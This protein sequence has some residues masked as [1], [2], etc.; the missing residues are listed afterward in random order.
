MKLS[1]ALRIRSVA[2]VI[3]ATLLS[4]N[5]LFGGIVLSYAFDGSDTDVPRIEQMSL[6]NTSVLK[7]N[8]PIAIVL[9]TSDDKNWVK[10]EGTLNIGYSYKL[11][12]G[13]NPPP[14]CSTVT[15][16]F[17]KLEAIEIL[18]LRT[19]AA[20]GQRNQTFWLMGYLPA[21][22]ALVSNCAEYRDL[23]QA[24]VV[25]VNSTSFKSVKPKGSSV[26]IITGG[27]Y[28][29]KLVDEAGRSEPSAV[30]QRL[31]EWQFLPGNYDYEAT[32]P[33]QKYADSLSFRVKNQSALDQ[34]ELEAK[35]ARDL[36]NVEGIELATQVES[37]LWQVDSWI[38]FAKSPSFDSLKVVPACAIPSSTNTLIKAV[39]EAKLKLKLSNST[40]F[41]ANLLSRCE[42]FQGK[43]LDLE[44]RVLAARDMFKKTKM[45]DAFLRIS[46][47]NLRIDCASSSITDLGLSTRDS[48]FQ[49][50]EKDF[51]K[52]EQ[53]ALSQF[54]CKPFNLRLNLLEK[55]YEKAYKKFSGS[56]Y[57]KFFEPQDFSQTYGAC[58]LS[59]LNTEDIE[60][61]ATD[62]EAFRTLFSTN[63]GKAEKLFKARKLIFDVTCSKSGETKFVTNNSGECPTG[64]NRIY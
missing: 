37:L 41:K 36:G 27:I 42:I 7:P 47:R 23:I 11:R 62:F 46:Y 1:R 9:K 38:E 59:V 33:C 5:P 22:K 29:P 8:D 25:I 15:T 63:L 4:L 52:L 61:M 10:I 48:A 60:I 50:V 20:N 31:Q 35:V 40:A 53:K 6:A 45:S 28:A 30:T 55:N 21:K 39:N 17:S 14:N 43:Y 12:P 19:T 13:S 2:K 24:P 64:Y 51:N 26:P 18:S 56:K 44:T 32:F 49:V 58:S 3:V 54:V 16:A 34:F 57:Q